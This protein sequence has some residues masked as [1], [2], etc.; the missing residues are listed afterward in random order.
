MRQPMR[1][2]EFITLL[3]GAA[4]AWPLA[5]RAQQD[6][7]VR[8]VGWLIGGAETDLGSHAA[9]AA[10]QEALTRLGWIE[11]RNLRIDRRFG[12]R[13]L[14]HIRAYGAELVGLMP[15]VIITTAGAPTQAA[16]QLTQTIPIVFTAAGD[17]VASGIVQ[18]ISRPE[19]NIT[20]FSSREPSIAGKCVELL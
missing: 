18:N 15:D 16:Q 14:D 2:R 3:G 7:R 5:A 12:G 1:R 8:R 20:G 9:R 4:A 13:D 10:L 17:A 6:G 19:G 11:G